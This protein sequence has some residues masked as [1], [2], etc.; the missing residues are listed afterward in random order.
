MFS[1]VLL[2]FPDVLYIIVMIIWICRYNLLSERTE[3]LTYRTH[4]YYK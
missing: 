3:D 1:F 4:A 2:T